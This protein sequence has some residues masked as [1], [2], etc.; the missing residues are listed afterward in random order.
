M[1]YHILLAMVVEADPHDYRMAATK[2]YLELAKTVNGRKP[3]DLHLL[4]ID[5]SPEADLT[6]QVLD[7][8]FMA[9][10]KPVR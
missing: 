3:V 2:G 8:C 9:T 6:K 7:C 4:P 1:K 10:S 5:G